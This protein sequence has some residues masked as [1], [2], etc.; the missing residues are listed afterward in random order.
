MKKAFILTLQQYLKSLTLTTKM[1]LYLSRAYIIP[2]PDISV[3]L[4][5]KAQTELTK[6]CTVSVKT[7]PVKL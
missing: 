1:R 4:I 7:I 2:S 5:S 6:L 3:L